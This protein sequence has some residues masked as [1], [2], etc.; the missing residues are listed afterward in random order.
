MLNVRKNV[1]LLSLK[2]FFTFIYVDL[3]STVGENVASDLKNRLFTSVLQQDL[4]FYDKNR[5]GEII[6][7][8]IEFTNSAPSPPLIIVG[9]VLIVHRVLA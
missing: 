4:T 2:A 1:V 3:L 8:Y 6:D 9:T 7:R 5:T